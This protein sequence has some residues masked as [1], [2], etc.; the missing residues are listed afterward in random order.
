[1]RQKNFLFSEL[2]QDIYK[3]RKKENIVM[4]NIQKKKA[5]KR[6]KKSVD[7]WVVTNLWAPYLDVIVS[8]VVQIQHPVE[9]RI[10]PNVQI[11]SVFHP[12]GHRLS[13]ILFHLDVVE[14]S[15]K[16]KTLVSAGT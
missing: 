3:P 15:A 2:P 1:M 9:L 11:V 4:H 16:K 5:K 12:F 6:D 13:C 7:V 14:F 10:A 8:V